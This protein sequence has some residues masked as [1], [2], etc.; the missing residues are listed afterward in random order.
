[1]TKM[2]ELGHE[3]SPHI[4]W[5][6]FV[7]DHLG[8]I[9]NVLHITFLHWGQDR[10]ETTSTSSVRM[11]PVKLSDCWCQ[12]DDEQ[13]SSFICKMALYSLPENGSI[14]KLKWPQ[15]TFCFKLLLFA[16]GYLIMVELCPHS[17]NTLCWYLIPR[18]WWTA[19]SPGCSGDEVRWC[20][21]SHHHPIR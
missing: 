14:P 12:G 7:G 5:Q 3:Q 9:S 19:A 2:K 4:P 17:E 11:D 21:H 8:S 16:I 10:R 13:A 6:D 18:W 1:M 20:L 15:A